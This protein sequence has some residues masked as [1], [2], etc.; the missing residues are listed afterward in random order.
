MK[1]EITSTDEITEISGVPVRH[2]SGLTEGGIECHVFV[3]RIA[4]S[5]DEDAS[6]FENEL[7]EMDPPKGPRTVNLRQIL[8]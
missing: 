8:S 3:H 1:I 2:W 4:V 6:A 7:R 5:N